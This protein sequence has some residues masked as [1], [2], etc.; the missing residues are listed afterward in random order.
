MNGV[1]STTIG[2]HMGEHPQGLD[3]GFTAYAD[4]GFSRYLR[5]AFLA[6]AGYDKEDVTK[7][8]VGIANLVSDR[9][10]G[11]GDRLPECGPVRRP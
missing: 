9:H 7:P 5:H 11:L 6:G 2:D 4:V 3:K 10:Q 1:A 8:V